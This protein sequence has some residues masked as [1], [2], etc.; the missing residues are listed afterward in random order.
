MTR[1]CKMMLEELQRR[2]YSP[3]TIRCYLSAVA[4]FTRYFHPPPD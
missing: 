3:G 2:N 1:Q 4:D